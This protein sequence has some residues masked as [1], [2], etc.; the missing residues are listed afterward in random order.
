MEA[1]TKLD[2]VEIKKL[3]EHCEKLKVASRAAESLQT[4]VNELESSL[5]QC[6]DDLQLVRNSKIKIQDDCDAQ[7]ARKQAACD[8]TLKRRQSV[9]DAAKIG[10]AHV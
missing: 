10:R 9:V 1:Q 4:K 2:A 5:T 3:T 8:E 7:I 6:K